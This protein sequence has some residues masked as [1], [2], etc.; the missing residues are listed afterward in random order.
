M[1]KAETGSDPRDGGDPAAPA[2]SRAGA[3]AGREALPGGVFTLQLALQRQ[4]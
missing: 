1:Q 4:H 3:G 2:D